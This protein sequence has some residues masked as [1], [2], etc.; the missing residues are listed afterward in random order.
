MKNPIIKIMLRI[1][2]G[3]K[4]ES[5]REKDLLS[6]F[7]YRKNKYLLLLIKSQYLVVTAIYY[8]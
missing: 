3:R 8:T 7:R 4:T 6:I 1:R 2:F 5:F